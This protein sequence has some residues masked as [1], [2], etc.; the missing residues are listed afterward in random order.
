MN[1]STTRVNDAL[2]LKRSG[3]PTSGL[4]VGMHYRRKTAA[5]YAA[6]VCHLL[7]S[8]LAPGTTLTEFL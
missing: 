5:R 3:V 6:V 2:S 8:A 1:S 4:T 7:P